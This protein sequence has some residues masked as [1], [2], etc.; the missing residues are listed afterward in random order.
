MIVKN[1]LEKNYLIP[2]SEQFNIR[3]HIMNNIVV[4]GT[5]N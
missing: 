4:C 5:T 3:R 1:W 2:L